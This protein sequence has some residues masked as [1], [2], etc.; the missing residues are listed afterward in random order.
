MEQDIG[1]CAAEASPLCGPSGGADK[2]SPAKPAAANAND[3]ACL[4]CGKPFLPAHGLN[5]ECRTFISAYG[6][7]FERATQEIEMS[8]WAIVDRDGLTGLP[9]DMWVALETLVSRAAANEPHE[10]FYVQ[11]AEGVHG[12]HI[13]KWSRSPFEGARMARVTLA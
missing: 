11:F 2:S 13:R 9:S 7:A 8:F 5:G 10:V 6:S 1:R 3:D 12:E 4:R